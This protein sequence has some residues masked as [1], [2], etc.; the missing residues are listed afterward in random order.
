MTNANDAGRVV[1][2]PKQANGTRSFAV[3]VRG[4]KVL[5]TAEDGDHD[6]GRALAD[7]I[8]ALGPAA[9]PAP[10]PERPLPAAAPVTARATRG[11]AFTVGQRVRCIVHGAEGEHAVVEV[12]SGDQRGRIKVSNFRRGKAWCPAHNFA[13]IEAS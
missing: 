2:F 4:V 10:I 9:I 11:A 6:A 5:V 7:A 12:G 8:A 3:V 1:A 13:P